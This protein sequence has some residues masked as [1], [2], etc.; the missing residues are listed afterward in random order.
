MMGLNRDCCVGVVVIHSEEELTTAR[1]VDELEV[2]QAGFVV[3]VVYDSE[4]DILKT[5]FGVVHSD[6]HYCLHLNSDK[7]E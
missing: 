2:V 3:S 4:F 1:L 5:D 7:T 6:F